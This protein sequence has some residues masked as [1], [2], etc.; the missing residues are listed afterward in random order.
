[1]LHQKRFARLFPDVS[2]PFRTTLGAIA[3]A[4]C[5]AGCATDIPGPI[6][7]D[8]AG[9]MYNIKGAPAHPVDPK[10]PNPTIQLAAGDVVYS[11]AVY[12]GVL[13]RRNIY[14][15]FSLT[16]RLPLRFLGSE[17]TLT[18]AERQFLFA[19]LVASRNDELNPMLGN[20]DCRD[21]LTQSLQKNENLI[22][23]T[24]V[25]SLHAKRSIVTN[26]TSAL[27]VYISRTPLEK[28]LAGLLPPIAIKYPKCGPTPISFLREGEE[29]E[30]LISG[31]P[32]SAR[33]IASSL[34]QYNGLNGENPPGSPFLSGEKFSRTDVTQ[35]DF[36][37]VDAVN[38]LGVERRW[39][40]ADWEASGICD[41]GIRAT[42]LA[43]LRPIKI[44]HIRLRTK[45]DFF[46]SAWYRIDPDDDAQFQVMLD[47]SNDRMVRRLDGKRTSLWST[48][49]RSS[50]KSLTMADVTA[51]IW[52]LNGE[53]V[54]LA[55]CKGW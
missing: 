31:L 38:P 44:K 39:S 6:L 13:S 29:D 1:M 12:G 26:G 2:A 54:L 23:N 11:T 33:S 48:L 16:D 30:L 15:P 28:E 21:K 40:L 9:P 32:G 24:F 10:A 37:G 36:S 43:K 18:D 7:A 5:L 45:P 25:A 8:G 55:N 19:V 27:N 34:F 47:T 4:A 20:T 51:I 52:E 22:W 46:A 42:N 17:N 41:D 50:L 3:A 14:L 35:V 49:G 53:R